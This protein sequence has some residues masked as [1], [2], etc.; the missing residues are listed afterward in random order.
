MTKPRNSHEVAKERGQ[1]FAAAPK[2]HGYDSGCTADGKAA[3]WNLYAH[4]GKAWKLAD[5]ERSCGMHQGKA[6]PFA[7]FDDLAAWCEEKLGI[8]AWEGDR[9]GGW[10]PSTTKDERPCEERVSATGI[11]MPPSGPCGKKIK[12]GEDVCGVHLG[13]RNRATAKAAEYREKT[14][15]SA[16]GHKIAQDAVAALEA[17]GIKSREHYHIPLA[18]SDPGRY[19]GE[20]RVHA[21]DVLAL[22]RK[23]DHAAEILGA[24]LEMD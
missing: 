18:G 3:N 19:T 23:L 2:T 8:T 12:P 17:H 13:A 11:R 20:V 9:W 24:E 4:P 14:E 7:T 15:S 16:A 5:G 22:L 10:H 6:K 1:V 21:E